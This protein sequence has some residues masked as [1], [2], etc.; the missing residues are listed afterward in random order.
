MDKQ[1][2]YLPDYTGADN[3]NLVRNEPH[4]LANRRFKC[5]TLTH[6]SFHADSLVITKEGTTYELKHNKDYVYSDI[7][8]KESVKVGGPV[9]NVIIIL[10]NR[11]G[12]K[13]RVTYRPLGLP[14]GAINESTVRLL[15]APEPTEISDSYLDIR[16][17]PQ[18]HDPTF[19][20]HSLTAIQQFQ[21]MLFCLEKIR[22]SVLLNVTMP[23]RHYLTTVELIIQ[24]LTEKSLGTFDAQLI[25]N[26]R[27]F[28]K[29][30]DSKTFGVERINN[31]GLI[32]E[33]TADSI[34]KQDFVRTSNEGYLAMSSFLKFKN[35]IYESYL[36]S[37]Y[38]QLGRVNG[39]FFTPLLAT[40][41]DAMI[42]ATLLFDS[43]SNIT[44]SGVKFDRMAYPSIVTKNTE[45]SV[46][47][48]SNSPDKKVSIIV[49]T[50]VSTRRVYTGLITRSDSGYLAEWKELIKPNDVDQT[51]KDIIKH[52]ADHDN[53]H[54]DD[55]SSI[56]L[57]LV[58]NLPPVTDYDILTDS[59]DR[60][61]MTWDMLDKFTRRF[62]LKNRPHKTE[63]LETKDEN[64]MRNMSVV[65]SP[66][67]TPCGEHECKVLDKFIPLTTTT[68][69]TT[70]APVGGFIGFYME[71]YT[72][73]TGIRAERHFSVDSYN[74]SGDISTVED[75]HPTYYNADGSPLSGPDIPEPAWNV[76]QNWKNFSAQVNLH[77]LLYPNNEKANHENT[78]DYHWNQSELQ[79]KFL[80]RV[81]STGLLENEPFYFRMKWEVI[82]E[83]DEFDVPDGNRNDDTLSTLSCQNFGPYRPVSKMFGDFDSSVAKFAN[84]EMGTGLEATQLYRFDNYE[85]KPTAIGE[86]SIYPDMFMQFSDG[87]SSMAAAQDYLE[88]IYEN[89]T[90]IQ[91]TYAGRKISARKGLAV[92]MRM[93]V[94]RVD[95]DQYESNV[96]D[97]GRMASVEFTLASYMLKNPV[98]EWATETPGR[99]YRAIYSLL[100]I[101]PVGFDHDTQHA[102]CSPMNHDI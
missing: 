65:F 9:A 77:A 32:T 79:F 70:K 25:I 80:Y 2:R 83:Y 67:G 57:D 58:E 54:Q 66:C 19:H 39:M 72:D 5:M 46:R 3:S 17:A 97:L 45:W 43:Y 35:T 87:V 78:R 7:D 100:N 24:S 6:G 44:N 38:T 47:K 76:G 53:P 18:E 11:L 28:K 51:M 30:F 93:H 40:L 50:E 98:T 96:K 74:G 92:R 49:A 20:Y 31:W 23:I 95:G 89:P 36:G 56:E 90:P 102:Y 60:K 21:Y 4:T 16:D 22:N 94:H 73:Q 84:I 68:T 52:V 41:A 91:E 14:I 55:A 1:I 81:F 62:L 86:I 12:R 42:G 8:T 71:D 99:A 75:K 101:T 15:D 29:T 69:T 37:D 82:G 33:Q 64:I 26:F 85:N 88:G 34:A 63:Q 10:N 13:F 27:E 48:V 59:N 61:M